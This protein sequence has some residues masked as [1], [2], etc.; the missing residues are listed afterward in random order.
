M[1]AIL[2]VIALAAVCAVTAPAVMASEKLAAAGGCNK[3][4]AMSKKVMGPSYKEIA[5]KYKGDAKAPALLAEH[6]RKGSKGVWGKLAM[7]PTPA[8]KFNDAD[9]NATIAWIL[10]S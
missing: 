7:P 9:L 3:C 10:K 2:G 1:K 5:A 4:H 6:V 8:N